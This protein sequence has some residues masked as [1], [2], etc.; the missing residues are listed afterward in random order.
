MDAGLRALNLRVDKVEAKIDTLDAKVD[1]V[2]AKVDAH[3]AETAKGFASVERELAGHADPIHR[4]LEGLVLSMHG[5][6]VKAKMPGIP[7]RAPASFVTQPKAPAKKRA[8]AR[9][10]K[11]P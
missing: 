1:T 6:M 8:V 9:S 7:S 3:R 5:A 11:R 2:D 10:R 4:Q